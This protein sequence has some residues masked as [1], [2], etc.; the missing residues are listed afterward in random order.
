MTEILARLTNDFAPEVT[1]ERVRL[2]WMPGGR[3]TLTPH[4][5]SGPVNLDIEVRAEDAAKVQAAFETLLAAGPHKP[6]F[7]LEHD[8]KVASV[9]PERFF[10]SDSPQPGIYA[11]GTLTAAGKE[12][13]AGKTHRGF[14][15]VFYVDGVANKPARIEAKARLNMGGFTNN[16]AFKKSL[17]LWAKEAQG[18]SAAEEAVVATKESTHMNEKELAELK[19]KLQALEDENAA[20]KTKAL[21]AQ[22]A[23]AIQAKESEITALQAKLAESQKLIELRAKED[24]KAAVKKAVEIGA[25]PAADTALQAKWEERCAKD[26]SAIEL[27]AAIPASP[28]LASGRLTSGVIVG[29]GD[30]RNAIKAYGEEKNSR[31]RGRIY[32][33]DIRA[34]MATE[35][36][37]DAV[38]KASLGTLVGSLVTQ[39]TL[40]LL[41]ISFP[42]L[43][44]MST[45]LTDQ[46]CLI[47]E[48]IITRLVT[49]PSVGTYHATNGYV[50]AE[51]AVTDVTLTPAT[52]DHKFV[53]IELMNNDLNATRRLLFGE[54]D[55]AVHYALAKDLFD[56]IYA[57]FVA[58]NY[59]ETATTEALA[60]FDRQTVIDIGVAM[61]SGS[62]NRNANT[63]TRTLLLNPT[64]FGKLCKD[65]TIVGN[66][67][68]PNAGNSIAD[69][70]LP[71]VHGFL[72]IEAPNLPT[73]ANLAGFG[74][75]ADAVALAMGIPDGYTNAL[76]GVPATA[77]QQVITNPDSGMSV[78][79]T[80]FVDHKL[81]KAYMRIAWIRV[82]GVGNPK[83]GQLLLSS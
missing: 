4:S 49:V 47:G 55:V 42:P 52:T 60:N 6:Y 16:P 48:G 69:G 19:A 3:H 8:D 40:D 38:I 31:E 45:K 30:Y 79:L 53:Q 73:S 68:N 80:E 61:Q 5:D 17:P 35:E 81:G 34:L 43:S 44:R 41:K 83:A 75:R 78:Q 39:R 58:A 2:Q 54:Q 56:T 46:P 36:G 25:L 65:T 20:L 82:A 27:L 9:W 29:A 63:G 33:K 70:T 62:A 24:A 50:G 76:P 14:S 74:M 23:A 72:P 7:D 64:Y 10:W 28:L 37:C 71:I 22:D 1:G 18:I 77:L 59:T 67:V 11:E 21:G 32:A 26:P 57:L 66:L 15:A 51:P 13:I 12:A